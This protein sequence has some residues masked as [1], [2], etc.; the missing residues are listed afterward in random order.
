[1]ED[2]GDLL[3]DLDD[4]GDLL[5]DLD[6]DG[7]LLP[8]LDGDGDLLVDFVAVDVLLAETSQ[9]CRRR[10]PNK[11]ACGTKVSTGGV[12]G[13]YSTVEQRFWLGSA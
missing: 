12:T 4:D 9:L 2:D 7:D 10:P 5:P 1:M 11:Q 3:P 8:D 6:G 13:M